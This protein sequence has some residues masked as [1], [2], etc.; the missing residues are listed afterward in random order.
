VSR[1]SDLILAL[2][3]SSTVLDSEIEQQLVDLRGKPVTCESQ[4]YDTRG[5]VGQYR[6]ARAQMTSVLGSQLYRAFDLDFEP[7]NMA[8][9]TVDVRNQA[10]AAIRMQYNLPAT[11]NINYDAPAARAAMIA[12]ALKRG[13]SQCVSMNLVGGLDTHFGTQVSHAINQR[14]GWNA[15]AD[16]VS[17]LRASPHPAGG[18]FMDHTTILAFSEFSR[19]PLINGAGGR[20]HHISSSALLMGAGIQHNL[21]FGR[22]GDINMAP[23]LIDR[24]TG[25]PDPKGM[26]ILPEHIIAT[27]LASAKLDYSITR[28]EPLP[29]LLAG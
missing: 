16:M 23:G 27:V 15:L 21:V 14:S 2:K 18:T 26:N 19:T 13:I 4:L 1:A 3:P 7:G 24:N 9:P 11:G 20:D 12:V 22:A 29:G 28:V 25:L 10:R 8:D 5:L 17:D 6:D